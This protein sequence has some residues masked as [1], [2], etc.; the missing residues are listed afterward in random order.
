[1]I[2]AYYHDTSP[3]PL[4]NGHRFPAE[5]YHRLRTCLL[6]QKVLL[7][8]ELQLAEPAT[9]EQLLRVHT[10]DYVAK[11]V[12]GTLDDR[13]IRRIGLPW[14]PLLV[15]RSRLSAGSTILAC[16]S[17]LE[18][19]VA[20]NLGGGTHHAYADH[21]EGYCVFND[22]AVA[23]RAMQA[24]GRI[25]QIVILD[26]DVHQGNGTAAIFRDDP[27]VFTFSIHGEKN[28]PYHK[29]PS[30]L[31]IGLPDGAGDEQY[32]EALQSGLRFSIETAR[33]EMAIYLAGADPHFNNSLGRLSLS[34]SGLAQRDQMVFESCT[35]AGLPLAVAMAGG[36]GKNIQDTVD[37]HIQTIQVAKSFW[38]K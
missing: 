33:A 6:A 30:D 14:S 13:E 1:M 16:R 38:R 28:F 7:P 31:D 32:L 20:F 24:E 34:K 4:P 11:V 37:I 23:S 27:S 21:G 17:A 18:D 10:L 5:K 26:A 3:I 2:K 9:D 29:E 25:H 35:R 36:Y 22:V 15:E 19:G 12:G 8:E